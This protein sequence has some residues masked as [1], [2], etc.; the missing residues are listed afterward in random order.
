MADPAEQA[1]AAGF[2]E[3]VRNSRA[4]DQ[5]HYVW[6]ASESLGLLDP[7]SGLQEVWIESAAG[8]AGPGDEVIDV[9]H[10]Y[11]P[12]QD[13][14]DR[15]VVTQ[16][17]YSTK[18]RSIP[19]GLS[20]LGEA[21][22]KFSQLE[23]RASQAFAVPEH[24]EAEYVL[25]S[26]RP[27]EPRLQ[28]AL[29]QVRR[30]SPR[31]V[32]AKALLG[33]L[34]L[35]IE[36]AAELC[37][38]IRL[39]NQPW[40]VQALRAAV[41]ER[42]TALTGG[43]DPGPAALLVAA[44]A[45]RAAG[46]RDGPLRAVD[47]AGFFGVQ[48][49]QL[50][51]APSQ[52][53]TTPATVQRACWPGLLAAVLDSATPSV[54]TAIGGV[55]K[56]TFAAAL[57][58]LAADRAEVVVYD[59]FGG[60][61][62]R[63]VEAGRHL[64]GAGLVQIVSEL[65]G[66]GWCAPLVPRLGTDS[67]SYFSAFRQR[68]LEAVAG[69]QA[70]TPGRLLLLVVDAADNAAIAADER[71]ERPF[72]RDLLTMAPVPGVR[73]AVTS[74]PE[75]VQLLEAAG[76]TLLVL[77]PFV[78]DETASLLQH[79]FGSVARAE[80][81]EFHALTAGNPRVQAVAADAAPDLP[82]VL[83][84]L[85]GD[86][87]VG[88]DPVERLLA[89]RL[90]AALLHVGSD[91]E[92]LHLLGRL[93][94]ILRPPIEVELLAALAECSPDLVR[95][96][97]ADFGSGLLVTEA[98]VRF[99][100]EP[101]ETFFRT[102]YGLEGAAADQV[103]TAL[104][105]EAGGSG[106]AA[107]VL[108]QV[109]WVAG[110]HEELMALALS[111]EALPT[112]NEVERRQVATLRAEF[113]LRA[114]ITVQDPA[115]VVRLAVVAGAAAAAGERRYTLLRD[116]ADLAGELIAAATLD[117]LHAASA[118]P[119]DWA[120]S[121]LGAE[122][123]MLAM[124][125]DRQ[126]EARSRLRAARAALHARVTRPKE[127]AGD[128]LGEVRP[129]QVAA[130]AFAAYRLDGFPAAERYL[131]GWR[132]PEW[133][134]A[135]T[136][137]FATRLV[138]R[139][140]LDPLKQM[141][142]ATASTA[143]GVAVAAALERTG[144]AADTGLVEHLWSLLD[145]ER[146]EVDRVG[147]S[148][149]DEADVVDR[150]VAWICAA[151][152]RLE[153]VPAAAA[154]EMVAAY[155]PARAPFSLGDRGR[156]DT[157][158]LL[159][160]GLRARLVGGAV[161]VEELL[162]EESDIDRASERQRAR[163][164]LTPL[165]PWLDGWACWALGGLSEE[166]ALE[167][168]R[169][170]PMQ[171]QQW[172]D[173]TVLRR[174]AG[175]IVMQLATSFD[176]PA[177][178]NAAIEVLSSAPAHSGLWGVA[179]MI[180]ALHGDDRFADAAFTAAATCREQALDAA[181][182]ADEATEGLIRLARAIWA[183]NAAEGREYASLGITVA[184]RIGDDAYQRWQALLGAARAAGGTA[185]DDGVL[186]A[187]RL[188]HV[189]ERIA[190][191]LN[192]E[193][194]E[195]QL[196]PALAGLAGPMV[197]AQAAQWR[198]RFFGSTAWQLGLAVRALRLGE[199]AP[200]AAAA[201][202]ACSDRI[203]LPPLLARLQE[204]GAASPRRLAAL[205]ELEW[206]RGGRSL[207]EGERQ[208]GGAEPDPAEADDGFRDRMAAG[209]ER[210]VTALSDV[211]VWRP[212]GMAEAARLLQ[213]EK[214]W[215]DV[216]PL[217]ERIAQLPVHHRAAAVHLFEGEP[218]FSASDRVAFVQAAAG[219]PGPSLAAKKAVQ[220]LASRFLE[221][222]GTEVVSGFGH[223]LQPERFAAVLDVTPQEVLLRALRSADASVAVSS[224]QR[225]YRL[226]AVAAAMTEP[227]AAAV[228]L[229]RG[230]AELEVDLGLP[231]FSR[232]QV[233]PPEGS[234]EPELVAGYLWALL[235]DPVPAMRWRATHA[236]R[237]LLTA[238]ATEFVAALARTAAA[239]ELPAGFVDDRFPFYGMHAAEALLVAVE[240]VSLTDPAAVLPVAETLRLL[241]GRYGDHWRMQLAWRRIRQRCRDERGWPAEGP[242]G[243]ESDCGVVADVPSHQRPPVTLPW[244]PGAAAPEF[245]F[246]WDLQ[247]YWFGELIR[248]FDVPPA[249][250][251]HQASEV[252]L[253]E[254][255]W[256]GNPA[257]KSDPRRAAGVFR[258]QAS[259]P[260][261]FNWPEVDDLHFYLSYH[262]LMTVAGRLSTTAT[263]WRDPDDPATE[264]DRW[265]EHF[266]LAR[267]DGFWAADAR[268][269]VPPVGHG[270][271]ESGVWRWNV[272][273]RD[274]VRTLLPTQGSVTMQ[275]S[276][277]D[278][279]YGKHDRVAVDS[280][281]VDRRTGPALVR[282]LQTAPSLAAGFQIPGE[283]PNEPT[284]EIG[285]FRAY[286]CID[287]PYGEAGQDR[288]DELA[289]DLQCPLP[290]VDGRLAARLRLRLR[291][292][293]VGTHWH[294]VEDPAA[295]M[296]VETWSGK[297]RSGRDPNGPS[298]YRAVA[299]QELVD[300]LVGAGD[301]ALLAE[302]R[303]ARHDYSSTMRGRDRDDDRGPDDEYVRFF[304]Y[305]PG[306]GWRDYRGDPVAG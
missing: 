302:V 247:Q 84:R 141:A 99:A 280:W 36:R 244:E 79:R 7:R 263:R 301:L 267:R 19:L 47:V 265:G 128:R 18:R 25:L 101:T 242:E 208:D 304:L 125:P 234:G 286:V 198:S 24:V 102:R 131:A 226:A 164:R 172:R 59:C 236:V 209:R 126:G 108:P 11:G 189:A 13:V 8:A 181:W 93:L 120:G 72:V 222:H 210:V 245:P 113:A 163:D 65:A 123:T 195:Q 17:K 274:F 49:R 151:A 272:Q 214:S 293:G 88:T 249:T 160:Y 194:D 4:G 30:S 290:A 251:L 157:G 50:L 205:Q 34:G 38:R 203:A 240:R 224:A 33:R 281:L 201:L 252:I 81:E 57:P 229:T 282:S 187:L 232:R 165:L 287:V 67:A 266:D 103:V 5:F 285:P 298:G 260:N 197:F 89:A 269:P 185:H 246:G 225:C 243:S 178:L 216:A 153:V 129:E 156:T 275:L 221:Q 219:L 124:Q 104:R 295:T 212:D 119:S 230:L 190:P 227:D 192:D 233:T 199:T 55:G 255:S 32:T 196:V 71:A 116:E 44:V 217:V 52:L 147:F 175:P 130:V 239:D 271:P 273:S 145:A 37:D 262:A 22:E 228:A 118:L 257:L 166:E 63:S 115:A 41:D 135:C 142:A 159:L 39:E 278:V 35:P 12:A 132:P 237:L 56:S 218:T 182:T 134:L 94:V 90:D 54:V 306:D 76:T 143:V 261:H 288:R 70:R 105:R 235:A 87:V 193:I 167:L 170:F 191:R 10:R 91:R 171:L 294:A 15:V 264:F 75:R 127:T 284:V 77:P 144:C 188:A 303:F 254:W 133:V 137:V 220:D 2:G 231:A 53:S 45:E 106:Y 177:V 162:G 292:D 305:T 204:T 1:P 296:R 179:A 43:F 28:T 176:D 155:L 136:S 148:R 253:T 215:F 200:L 3:T 149:H 51:P 107:A 277:M 96:F 16:L 276:A 158:L 26:N 68:L 83:A 31:S 241:A 29:D 180:T 46:L 58:M 97:V 300:L 21:F 138:G 80:V 48:P 268:R 23:Q 206:A 95:S 213:A 64:A 154:V 207:P 110:R 114:G 69:I 40:A 161:S 152:V 86:G 74:R 169:T 140:E 66:R 297:E 291:H 27:F 183:F 146:L 20:E 289:A 100:D 202:A 211:E 117:D 122:A 111:E 279:R 259:W 61:G 174:F 258:E 299:T 98:G 14:F 223:G 92:R 173:E 85:A 60:G 73:I 238:G 139:E 6:A 184:S 150:G 270:D 250:V 42:A 186:L 121:A 248:C 9:M 62:Y 78:L 256:R 283:E 112:A 109:L 168:L 82:A